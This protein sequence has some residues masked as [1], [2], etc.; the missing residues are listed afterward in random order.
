VGAPPEST[1]RLAKLDSAAPNF[2]QRFYRALV[3]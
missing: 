2:P 3:K 1:L